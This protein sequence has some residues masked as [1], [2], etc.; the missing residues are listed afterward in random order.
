MRVAC[1]LML[2]AVM[3]IAAIAMTAGTASAQVELTVEGTSDHCGAVEVGLHSAS[4]D[5]EIHASSTGDVILR[6]FGSVQ[7]RCLY[8]FTGYVDENGSGAITD[9]IL[10]PPEIGTCSMQP[11][12]EV[13]LGQDVWP[14]QVSEGASGHLRLEMTACFTSPFGTIVCHLPDIFVEA[15]GDHSAH[16][17]TGREMTAGRPTPAACSNNPSLAF[18][19]EWASEHSN[20]E[21][22]H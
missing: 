19:G 22:T 2:L 7:S 20:V 3:A 17:Q 8:E 18:Q 10:G 4:G 14:I 12:A 5:C 15:G 16:L 11:C 6:A 13:G 21:V 9:Q 1:K